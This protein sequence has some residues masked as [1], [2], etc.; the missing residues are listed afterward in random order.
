MEGVFVGRQPIYDRQQN[1]YA[2]ELLFRNSEQNFAQIDDPDLATSELIVNALTEIGLN[3]IIDNKMGFINLTRNFVTGSLPIPGAED[4][5]VLEVLEDIELDD[6]VLDGIQKLKQQKYIIAL[7]DFIFHPHLEPLVQI[8]DIIKIDLMALSEE[9]L[10]DHVNRLKKFPV[11]LLAEKVE[12]AEE[13]QRCLEMGFEYFQGYYF[14]KPNIVSAKKTPA[15]RM[16][17]INLL[18]KISNPETDIEEIEKLI[19]SDVTLSFRL[20]RFINSSKY[21]LDQN[22]DSIKHAIMLLGLETVRSISCL[23]M[24]TTID[25]KPFELFVSA[26]IRARMCE[27]AALQLDEK[28]H[29]ATYFTVGLFSVMDAIMD[30]PMQEVLE[31]LPLADSITNAILKY[32][33]NMGQALQVSLAYQQGEWEILSSKDILNCEQLRDNY[34]DAISWTKDFTEI[35]DNPKAA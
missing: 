4:R 1:V 2:Y 34:L 28:A 30:Q 9:E 18:S 32:E 20:I 19:A 24:F 15:N 6:K 5:L 35:L 7:D 22:I 3:N 11:K 10:E 26:L 8:A 31:Q 16:A 29:A 17:L 13:Y 33:G 21:A 27:L 23:I 14:A 25:D 12:T